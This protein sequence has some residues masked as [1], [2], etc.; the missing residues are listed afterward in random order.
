MKSVSS[1]YLLVKAFYHINCVMT[2]YVA[3]KSFK[4]NV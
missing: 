4:G 2:F 1:A 3:G